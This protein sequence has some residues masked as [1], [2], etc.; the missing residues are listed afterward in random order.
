MCHSV[1]R[2]REL[3]QLQKSYLCLDTNFFWNRRQKSTINC[4][5]VVSIDTFSYIHQLCDNY[6][7]TVR[8][9]RNSIGQKNYENVKKKNVTM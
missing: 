2:T 5:Y 7:H 9:G 8:N 4:T 3:C 6:I 1:F